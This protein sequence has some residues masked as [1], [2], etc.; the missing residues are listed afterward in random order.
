MDSEEDWKL[1]ELL[2]SEVC[3]QQH[4]AETSHYWWLQGVGVGTN[5]I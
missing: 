5:A 2:V 4:Q 1:P 3:D